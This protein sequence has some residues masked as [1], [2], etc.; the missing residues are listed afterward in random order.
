MY[1]ASLFHS[2]CVRHTRFTKVKERVS[3][4]RLSS[5]PSVRPSVGPS[6]S[7]DSNI[8]AD[9]SHPEWIGVGEGA[10]EAEHKTL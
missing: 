8:A 2:R 4:R 3:P 9:R 7:P 6:F 10:N 1:T 5:L